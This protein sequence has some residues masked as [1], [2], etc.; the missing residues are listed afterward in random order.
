ML[1]QR[2]VQPPEAMLL[3]LQEG[4]HGSTAS[5]CKHVIGWVRQSQVSQCIASMIHD[6]NE[7]EGKTQN[8]QGGMQDH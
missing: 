2:D 1:G 6:G 8:M 4:L 7:E 3:H 5:A